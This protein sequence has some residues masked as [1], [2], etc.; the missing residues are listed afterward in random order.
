MIVEEGDEV[1]A[2][3][4]PLEDEGEQVRLPELIGP[5]PLEVA[6]LV[7]MRP[8]GGLVQLVAGLAQARATAE[9]LAGSAGPRRSIWLIRS[10][11]QS[12]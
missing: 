10:Q 9:G 12:G 2:A 11:P 4:L 5:G 8:R 3:V 6:D 7:G 1:D